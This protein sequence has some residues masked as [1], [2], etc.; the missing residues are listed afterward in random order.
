MRIIQ[1]PLAERLLDW[2]EFDTNGGCWL[3]FGSTTRGYG[4]T[5]WKRGPRRAH[6]ASWEIHHG[7]IS[8]DLLVCHRCDVPLCV[9][10]AHLFLGTGAENS[11][12]MSKKGRG[13]RRRGIPV[14][15]L[16][17]NERQR[18]MAALAEQLPVTVIARELGTT[19]GTVRHWRN[20]HTGEAG[21][22]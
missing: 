14:R 3:W 22:P 6:R 5:P 11:A 9:N 20:H 19:P 17:P 8:G 1:K 21:R 2:V 7:A 4:Q 15:R 16:S 12:D 18:L 10:P 13:S